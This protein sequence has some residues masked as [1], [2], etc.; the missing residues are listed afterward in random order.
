MTVRWRK[1]SYT[2]SANDDHC[3]EVG[4][5]TQGIG[6]RDSKNPSHGH[7]SLTTTQFATL[8]DQVKNHAPR[9]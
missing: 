2:G 3:V 9:A 8:L 6:V 7:L 5:L 1:S 4:R